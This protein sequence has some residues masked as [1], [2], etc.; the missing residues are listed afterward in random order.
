MSPTP[1]I[2]GS[3]LRSEKGFR[4][5]GTR[6]TGSCNPAGGGTKLQLSVRG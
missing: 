4:F 2:C 6:A 3:S 1:H 5:S